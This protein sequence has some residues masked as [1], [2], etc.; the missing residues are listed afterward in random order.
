MTAEI[1]SDVV[2]VATFSSLEDCMMDVLLE[3]L[4]KKVLFGMFSTTAL[5]LLVG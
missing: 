2:G 3:R 5:I 1:N 4:G